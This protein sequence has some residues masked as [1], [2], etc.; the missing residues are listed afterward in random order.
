MSW[1]MQSCSSNKS[2]FQARV[3][4]NG[5][6]DPP[7]VPLSSLFWSLQTL[8]V[9]LWLWFWLPGVEIQTGRTPVSTRGSFVCDDESNMSL[10]VINSWTNR[11]QPMAQTSK[12][13]RPGYWVSV[14]LFIFAMS[15]WY[16]IKAELRKLSADIFHQFF[17]VPKC[18]E[19][20]VSILLIL[21]AHSMRKI[22]R[23]ACRA[24]AATTIQKCLNASRKQRQN[25]I[26]VS[27]LT[28]HSHSAQI[29]I[30]SLQSVCI[31]HH[32]PYIKPVY[33]IYI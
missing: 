31:Y 17:A 13:A 3:R 23:R 18:C 24:A 20:S 26:S 11:N 2:E 8:G 4:C 29:L 32:I 16:R 15:F 22:P 33:D 28:P 12:Q 27:I 6:Q 1:D 19:D 10:T 25:S 9:C 30:C 7:A 5:L 14:E 21:C